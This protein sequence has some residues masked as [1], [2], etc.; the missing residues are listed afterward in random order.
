MLHRVYRRMPTSDLRVL[1]DALSRS[2]LRALF[3]EQ[4]RSIAN[5][6]TIRSLPEIA[7]ECGGHLVP[8][9]LGVQ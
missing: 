8:W 9:I 1:F 2:P 3:T 6:L 7:D 4:R 5:E